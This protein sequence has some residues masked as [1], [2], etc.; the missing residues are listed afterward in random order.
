MVA[1]D[2]RFAR[3]RELLRFGTVGIANTLISAS[4]IVGLTW[5]GVDPFIANC[6]GYVD[7]L[8]RTLS[9]PGTWCLRKNL[10]TTT[11]PGKAITIA[12]DNIT[13]DCNDFEIDGKALAT[14][15]SIGVYASNRFNATV[16]H[17]TITGFRTGIFLQSATSGGGHVVEHNRVDRN[18]WIGVRLEGE[19][20]VVRDNLV[21]YT[22]GT[23]SIANAYGIYGSGSIDIVDNMIS[24]VFPGA[25]GNSYG[26][27]SSG[28]LRGS[29]ARNHV[30]AVTLLTSSGTTYGIYGTASGYLAVRS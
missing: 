27:Y 13:L 29:I 15:T 23:T 14:S 20:S 12:A 26:I 24:D 6:V 21:T 28:D 10:G 30:A 4:L 25:S 7:T 19:G 2:P 9:T 22:G 3:A 8:P 17:C 16:R 1:P 18:T 11:I 5:S